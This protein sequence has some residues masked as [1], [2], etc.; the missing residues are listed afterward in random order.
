LWTIGASEGRGGGTKRR[1]FFDEIISADNLWTAWREFKLGKERKA[2][3]L[4]FALKCDVRKFFDSI[5]HEI[6]ISLLT[7]KISDPDCIW[8]LNKLISS[9]ETTGGKGIPIG[10]VTSQLFSNVYLNELDQFVK[11]NLRIKHYMRYC[12]DFIILHGDL[13]YL[14]ALISKFGTFLKCELS[15]SLH[16]RKIIIRKLHQGIDFLGYVVRPNH[17]VLRTR[18][19]RRMFRKLEQAKQRLKVGEIDKDRFNQSFQSYLGLLTH[20]RGYELERKLWKK[21]G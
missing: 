17:A 4:E 10:N 1:H 7:K 3:V 21:F 20:C 8:L 2:D 9:F 6:L 11:H 19:K 13:C 12:D 18:T 5:D 15:L 16:P 14:E